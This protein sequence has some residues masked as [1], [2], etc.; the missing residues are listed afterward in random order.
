MPTG[1]R[2]DLG[3]DRVFAYPRLHRIFIE[4]RSLE[5]LEQPICQLNEDCEHL[6]VCT[7][8]VIK[9]HNMLSECRR[10]EVIKLVRI[11]NASCVGLCA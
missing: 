11:G 3:A 2:R 7:G 6:A 1:L 5:T 4:L 9:L 8:P 10:R